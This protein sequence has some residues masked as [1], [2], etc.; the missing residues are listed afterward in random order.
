MT[1]PENKFRAGGCTA[2]VFMNSFQTPE[3]LKTAKNVVL[4]R[5]YKDKA[6]AYQVSVNGA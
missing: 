5:T 4:E 3:G 2:T 6:G 1:I